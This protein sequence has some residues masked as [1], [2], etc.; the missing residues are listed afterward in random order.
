MAVRA[1]R[2]G[3]ARRVHRARAG[4]EAEVMR[5]PFRRRTRIEVVGLVEVPPAPDGRQPVM[6]KLTDV[7]DDGEKVDVF[8]VG[9]TPSEAARAAFRHAADLMFPPSSE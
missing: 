5:W 1:G 2:D 8:G 7:L 6:V 9:A 3:R 4:G